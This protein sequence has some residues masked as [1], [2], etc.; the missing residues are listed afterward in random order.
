[1]ANREAIILAG[2]LG[3][4]L[5]GILGDYPKPM[6]EIHGRP[7]LQYLINYL[8]ESGISRVVLSI[9][10]KAEIFTTFFNQTHSKT[11][12]IYSIENS[13]LGTGGGLKMALSKIKSD[14]ALVVNGDTLFKIDIPALYEFHQS[15]KADITMALKK[16]EDCQRYGKVTIDENKKVTGFIPKGSEKAGLIDAGNFII[17]KDL[18]N[19]MP[20]KFSFEKD[21]VQKQYGKLN[22]FALP[23][24]NYFIDIGI[25]E[26]YERSKKEFKRF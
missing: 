1:M 14:H 5:R 8:A 9:G 3:T 25:P 6:A 23:F 21:F 7:F 16:M 12:V 26:D 20:V 10:Y 18:L 19:N 15:K 17:R 22:I 4:R 11:D 13:P 2:G 24:D